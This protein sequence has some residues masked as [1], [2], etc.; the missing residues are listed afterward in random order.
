M[1]KKW[2]INVCPKSKLQIHEIAFPGDTL[3]E[4]LELA[5]LICDGYIVEP[6]DTKWKVVLCTLDNDGDIMQ[7]VEVVIP[8]MSEES[9]E[10]FI[11]AVY[12]G[13]KFNSKERIPPILDD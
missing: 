9:T 1:K 7:P 4:A 12:G 6:R 13:L 11:N 8:E 10:K 5:K 2:N 3:E